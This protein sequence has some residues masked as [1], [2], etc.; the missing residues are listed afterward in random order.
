MASIKREAHGA[1]FW[2]LVFQGEIFMSN[3]PGAKCPRLIFVDSWRELIWGNCPREQLSREGKGGRGRG[4]R[5][6]MSSKKE[7]F[8]IELP[9]VNIIH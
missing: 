6:A 2:G 7:L 1:I 3:C 4:G 5:G 8:S 9:L